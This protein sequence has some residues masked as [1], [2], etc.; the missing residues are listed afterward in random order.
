[1]ERWREWGLSLEEWQDCV[2]AA[3]ELAELSMGERTPRA[4]EVGAQLAIAKAAEAIPT[5][6]ITSD[7]TPLRRIPVRESMRS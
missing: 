7:T 3:Q 4:E 6:D 5:P 1:M 2:E